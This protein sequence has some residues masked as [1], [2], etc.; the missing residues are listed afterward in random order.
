MW[1]LRA[2]LTASCET[3]LIPAA[4]TG[5]GTSYDYQPCALLAAKASFKKISKIPFFTLK[6]VLKEDLYKEFRIELLQ[7]A[8]IKSISQLGCRPTLQNLSLYSKALLLPIKEKRLRC[9][10]AFAAWSVWLLTPL[11]TSCICL[12][13]IILPDTGPTSSLYYKGGR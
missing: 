9:P 2:V 4:Q 1:V 13:F 11:S 10:Q 7:T 3:A 12:F 5:K 6:Y 8:Q